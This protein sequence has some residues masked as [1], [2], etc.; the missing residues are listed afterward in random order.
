MF[1]ILDPGHNGKVPGKRSPD[2]SLLEYKWAREI[3]AKLEKRLDELK[4][5]HTRTTYSNED[6]GPEIGLTK[7]CIRANAAIK[8]RLD[9]SIFVSIHVNAAGAQG[10]WMA[11]RGWSVFVSPKASSNSKKLASYMAT[12]AKVMGQKVRVPDPQH[13]Y[14]PGNFTVLNKTSMPAVLVENLFQDN[15]EDVEYLLSEEGKNTLVEVIIK[16]ICDYFGIN[17]DRDEE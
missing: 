16:G 9:K 3:T 14:W 10:K 5:E 1:V 7:R 4:I 13:L 6:E 11:A 2:G 12:S 8:G 17:Y 15:K